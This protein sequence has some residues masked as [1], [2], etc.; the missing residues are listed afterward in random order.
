MKKE[1]G[2][3]L[4][5]VLVVITI[6]ATLAGLVSILIP[7]GTE[8]ANIEVCRQ[9]VGQLVGLLEVADTTRYPNHSGPNL[10]LWLVARGQIAGRDMLENLFCPGDMEESFKDVGEE[11]YKD[12]DLA[13]SGAYGHLTSYAARDQKDKKKR[14]KRG[15]IPP[16][17]LVADDS[18]DH[19]NKKG[20][21]IGLTGGVAKWRDKLDDY[22]LSKDHP[23]TVGAD[24]SIE[25]LACL[26]A[27]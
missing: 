27:D 25:E 17:V 13:K 14:A 11:A 19:H 3:T 18:E 9:H 2:F 12:L 20:I 15:S 24:S 23:L 6:I 16:V 4:I 1:S 10:L 5:E 21:V 7:R 8:R 22:G 26:T